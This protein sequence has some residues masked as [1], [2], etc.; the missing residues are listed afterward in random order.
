MQYNKNY[1]FAEIIVVILILVIVAIGVNN[2]SATGLYA[3]SYAVVEVSTNR[4]VYV[5]GDIVSI[6]MSVKSQVPAATTV[7]LSIIRPNN[8]FITKYLETDENG[9]VKYDYFLNS[10]NRKGTYTVGVTAYRG[11][12][13]FK[14]KTTFEVR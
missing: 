10:E 11:D 2:N 9:N 1:L 8:I 4:A 13:A 5:E 12:D 7:A 3:G 6:F 14:G